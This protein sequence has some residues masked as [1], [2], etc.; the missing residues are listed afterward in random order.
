MPLTVKFTW[1]ILHFCNYKCIFPQ[2]IRH[3]LH[4]LAN[5]EL[6]V[7]HWCC[8]IPCLD[9]GAHHKNFV[10]SR[11]HLQSRVRVVHSLQ[12]QKGGSRWVPDLGCEQDAEEQS[13][14]FTR[15]PQVC[16]SRCETGQFVKEEALL[17]SIKMNPRDALTQSV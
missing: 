11:C 10:S 7:V 4:T 16:S 1:V 5:L 12:G 9:F 3:F 17:V 2:D 15:L 6:Y 13:T 8:K 14:P